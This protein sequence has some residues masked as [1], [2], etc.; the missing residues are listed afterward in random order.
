[1]KK[2]S[3]EI[4][5]Q[6]YT[7]CFL[8]K[9]IT[10]GAESTRVRERAFGEIFGAL[11]HTDGFYCFPSRRSFRKNFPV[12]AYLIILPADSAPLYMTVPQNKRI[13]SLVFYS[14]CL[15]KKEQFFYFLILIQKGTITINLQQRKINV[16]VF[17]TNNLCSRK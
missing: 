13:F 7:Y 3:R 6:T 14:Y 1:M 5:S 17:G 15:L 4:S 11:R 2:A 12:C 16:I 9:Y 8:R 10:R